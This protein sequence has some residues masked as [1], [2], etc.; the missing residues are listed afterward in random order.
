M[1]AFDNMD[2]A[3]ARRTAGVL[4]IVWAFRAPK[5]ALR[6]SALGTERHLS[7]ECGTQ[8]AGKYTA[9]RRLGLS[10]PLGTSAIT[11]KTRTSQARQRPGLE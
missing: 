7:R 1:L 9:I 11:E 5:V 4:G 8:G 3:P 10:L 2:R 6:Q